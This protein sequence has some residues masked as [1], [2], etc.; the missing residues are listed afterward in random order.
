MVTKRNRFHYKETTSIKINGFH[1]ANW[2]PLASTK[3]NG[4]RSSHQ[5]CSM[6]H[7][8]LRNFTKF[9]KQFLRQSLFF[10]KGADLRSVTL[11]KKKLWHRCSP[12]NFAK[13]LR[14][15]FYR[16][17]LGD[18]ACL[19]STKRNGFHKKKWLPLYRNG[20]H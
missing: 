14:K 3:K 17:P 16:T 13:F 1:N 8:V 18:Y 2:L 11:L 19:A 10:N 7:V 15:L 4:V 5:S 20:F 12:G 9:T 6:K